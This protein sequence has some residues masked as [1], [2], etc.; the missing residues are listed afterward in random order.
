MEETYKKLKQA[1]EAMHEETAKVLPKDRDEYT[2]EQN[3]T[4]NGINQLD[5]GLWR[6]GVSLGLEKG[7]TWKR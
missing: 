7:L 3:D 4:E 1:L 5:W 2:S 6:L